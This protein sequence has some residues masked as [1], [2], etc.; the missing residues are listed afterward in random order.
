MPLLQT[1]WFCGRAGSETAVRTALVYYCIHSGFIQGLYTVYNGAGVQGCCCAGL[2]TNRG[3]A[4]TVFFKKSK[5]EGETELQQGTSE[6]PSAH[7]KCIRGLKQ[8]FG[9]P[10]SIHHTVFVSGTRGSGGGAEFLPPSSLI[11]P[12]NFCSYFVHHSG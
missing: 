4:S 9:A 7:K 5:N 6:V 1:I 10:S 11:G 8:G 3:A 12:M 2:A